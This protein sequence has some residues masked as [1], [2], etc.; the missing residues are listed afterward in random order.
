MQSNVEFENTETIASTE[1]NNDP[2]MA[3]DV[4]TNED[5]LATP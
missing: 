4:I 3:F 1:V 5:A 2:N